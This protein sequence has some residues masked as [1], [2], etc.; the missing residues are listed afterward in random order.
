MERKL[1]NREGGGEVAKK[2]GGGKEVTKL[3]R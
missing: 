1:R 3:R 2:G